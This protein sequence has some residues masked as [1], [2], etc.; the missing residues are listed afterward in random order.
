MT[1][2][3][4]FQHFYSPAAGDDMAPMQPCITEKRTTDKR[5]FNASVG[6]E[7]VAIRALA[8][9]PQREGAR[10]RQGGSGSE[11]GGGSVVLEQ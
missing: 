9:S 8:P 6:M 5:R 3:E 4:R 1:L 2:S 11:Y 10:L 7:T